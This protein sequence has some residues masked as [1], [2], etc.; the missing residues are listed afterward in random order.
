M[1]GERDLTKLLKGLTPKLQA[2]VYVFVSV[3][4]LDLAVF[5]DLSPKMV[6]NEEEGVTL[7]LQ[8]HQADKAG[9]T[10]QSVFKCI[11]CEVHSSLE[12]VGL[13][14]ALAEALTD[15]GISANVV[16]AF[17]HDHIF[18]PQEDAENAVEALLALTENQG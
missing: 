6:F 18:V 11:T 8:Q 9:F 14:A 3:L 4:T 17:Y 5:A 12:A 1:V 13:T 16:A 15:R 10:Y 7:L 2:E